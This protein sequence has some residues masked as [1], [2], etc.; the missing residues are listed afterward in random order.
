MFVSP[1]L[2]PGSRWRFSCFRMKEAAA[3][4][5][6]LAQCCFA[7]LCFRWMRCGAWNLML[8]LPCCMCVRTRCVYVGHEAREGGQVDE[9]QLTNLGAVSAHRVVAQIMFNPA[10]QRR[11]SLSRF[12]FS[13]GVPIGPFFFFFCLF[14]CSVPALCINLLCVCVLQHPSEPLP[15][16]L[17]SSVAKEQRTLTSS[18]RAPSPSSLL[19][20]SWSS[21]TL[22]RPTLP[23]S[24]SST[25]SL[26]TRR[27]ET[28]YEEGTSAKALP[29]H[30]RPPTRPTTT[31]S[32]STATNSFNR[33]L[34]VLLRLFSIYPSIDYIHYF[35][36][37]FMH[38]EEGHPF[39]LKVLSEGRQKA[40][41]WFYPYDRFIKQMN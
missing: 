35:I 11:W 23:I 28:A 32:G 27:W 17:F 31:W 6:Q 22:T 1:A 34:N 16:S 25:R 30:G 4:L 24:P 2:H 12:F 19:R 14:G 37:S 9:G 13:S 15:V 20:T 10:R 38:N 41:I 39:L 33:N 29:A 8:V 21:P 3:L 26:C 7:T 36:F 5:S 40:F 18:S